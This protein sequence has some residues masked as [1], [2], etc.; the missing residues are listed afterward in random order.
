MKTAKQYG[1]NFTVLRMPNFLPEP[2]ITCDKNTDGTDKNYEVAEFIRENGIK[3]TERI[4]DDLKVLIANNSSDEFTDHHIMGA[5]QYQRM[6]VTNP[7]MT[8]VFNL[9]GRNT[10]VPVN[11]MIEILTEWK[12]FLESLDFEHSLSRW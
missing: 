5:S 4:I 8:C 3:Y 11:D 10:K 1:L 9:M 7:P 12:S 6:E 2:D